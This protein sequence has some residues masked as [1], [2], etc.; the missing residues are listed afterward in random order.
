MLHSR[1]YSL[2]S[3]KKIC[4]PNSAIGEWKY[5]FL[6]IGYRKT[7]YCNEDK[8]LDFIYFSDGLGKQVTQEIQ[9][10]KLLAFLLEFLCVCRDTFLVNVAMAREIAFCWAKLRMSDRFELIKK[11]Y[12]N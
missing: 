2:I 9:Q 10:L 5:I 6:L 1:H 3:S 8:G 4:D 11:E 7:P 12:Y